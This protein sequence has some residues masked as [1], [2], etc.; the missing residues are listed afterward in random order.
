MNGYIGGET[1]DYRNFDFMTNALLKLNNE[2][3]LAELQS[4]ISRDTS[5]FKI[6]SIADFTRLKLISFIIL[7]AIIPLT[8]IA[9]G[10]FF[11]FHKKKAVRK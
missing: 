4:R 2:E 7:F 9:F 8:V 3:E 1:G 10:F 6:K 5:F 11:N